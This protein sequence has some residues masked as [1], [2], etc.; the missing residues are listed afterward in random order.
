VRRKAIEVAVECLHIDL[1]VRHGLGAVE[2]DRHAAAA[3]LGD[4]AVDRHDG[5]ERI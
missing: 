4:E 5:A 2:Q 3:C 1:H